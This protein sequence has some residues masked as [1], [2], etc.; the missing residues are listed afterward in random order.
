VAT[1]KLGYR[2]R[3][4]G[5]DGPVK[6]TAGMETKMTATALPRATPAEA[7]AQALLGD[8]F[9]EVIKLAPAAAARLAQ[10]KL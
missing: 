6:A 4:G 2:V 10:E 7:R 9:D 3:L 5:A 8:L 1:I